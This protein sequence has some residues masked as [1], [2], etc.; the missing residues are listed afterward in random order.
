MQEEEEETSKR[1]FITLQIPLKGRD[2][3]GERRP[4]DRVKIG[5]LYG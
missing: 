1:H 4:K 5:L 2:I 3:A